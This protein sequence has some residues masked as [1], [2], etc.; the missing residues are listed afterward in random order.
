MTTPLID[1]DVHDRG[2][3]MNQLIR[4]RPPAEAEDPEAEAATPVADFDGGAR[5]PPAAATEMNKVIR[6]ALRGRA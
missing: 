5:L 6:R 4:R 1:D 2:T 3:D